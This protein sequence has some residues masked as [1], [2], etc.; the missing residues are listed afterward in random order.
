MLRAPSHP[1]A[2]KAGR[3]LAYRAVLYD[4]IGPG[5]HLCYWCATPVQWKT[6]TGAGISR[7]EL[8]VDH[9]DGDFRN[10]RLENLA[11]ACNDCNVLRARI[12]LWEERTGLPISTL[13]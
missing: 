3:V 4:A 8:A 2:D 12:R 13:L 10:D 6:R 11:A 1:L 7:G 9:L 5:L